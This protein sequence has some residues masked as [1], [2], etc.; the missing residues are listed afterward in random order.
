MND[1]L[2]FSCGDPAKREL[3]TRSCGLQNIEPVFFS[4]GDTYPGHAIAKIEHALA[5]LEGRDEPFVMWVDSHDSIVLDGVDAILNKYQR[6][7]AA[8]VISGEKNC[9]PDPAIATHFP[10]PK[11]PYHQ[12]PWRFI[13]SGSWIGEMSAVR[14]ALFAMKTK[15][16]DKWPGDDQR[17]W[18]EWFVRGYGRQCCQVDAGCEIFQTMSGVGGMELGP[19]GGNLV[20]H[21]QPKVLH[22]N[23]N[24]PNIGLWYRTLTGDLGWKGN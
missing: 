20:T 9:W 15:Y 8:I 7:G 14:E 5:F 6:I 21:S 3:F 19:S 1:L 12:S 24:T 13:N 17:C 23:G 4:Y 16:R 10:Y 22:F 18:Q 11:P 2:V